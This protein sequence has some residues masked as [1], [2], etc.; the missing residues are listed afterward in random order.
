MP[1]TD[2]TNP[3]APPRAVPPGPPR[4]PILGLGA[5]ARVGVVVLGFSLLAD[6]GAVPLVGGLANGVAG[7]R[8]AARVAGL[9]GLVA[10]FLP[11]RV[12]ARADQP[13]EEL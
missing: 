12:Q 11:W 2:P 9:A 5:I 4:R 3:Y 6:P 1:D 7:G 13:A 10:A 8:L